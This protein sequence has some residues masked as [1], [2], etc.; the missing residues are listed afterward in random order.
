MVTRR[1]HRLRTL[2]SLALFVTSGGG[3]QLLDAIVFHSGPVGVDVARVNAGDHCHAERCE[4]GA[5]IASPP[6]LAPPVGD[7]RAEPPTNRVTGLAPADAPRST[8][9]AGPLGSRAPPV[10][11]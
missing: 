8:V 9:V 2:L 5:P 10:R 7:G 11:S 1:L 3:A 4:L 6:P